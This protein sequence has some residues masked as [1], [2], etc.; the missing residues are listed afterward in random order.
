[1]SGTAARPRVRISTS[2]QSADPARLAEEMAA[3]A[4]SD[5][6]H[7]DVM[8]NHFVPRIVGGLG[9][10]RGL[11]R[12]TPLP[13]DCHLL[14]DDPDRWATAY[15]EA[16]AAGV[17]VHAEAVRAPVT[18]LRAIRA[19]GA[20]AGL[21]LMPATPVAGLVPLLAEIDIL[22]L[23][24]VEPTAGGSEPLIDLVLPRVAAARRLADAYHP[25]LRIQVDGGISAATIERC[26]AAGADTFTPGI[27]V[28]SADRPADAVKDLRERAERGLASGPASPHH[29][30]NEGE[31][32]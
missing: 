25:G 20:E 28:F 1:M 17:T 2:I 18:T 5:R 10:V 12:S 3:V 30:R 29:T 15:A 24:A 32:S 14:I 6:I 11:C 21:A 8:D 16:G 31:R 19:A 22:L 27:A 4:D 13:V 7:A 26:A 9:Q 23:L